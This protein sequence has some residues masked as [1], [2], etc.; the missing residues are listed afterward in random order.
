MDFAA[1]GRTRCQGSISSQPEDTLQGQ[2]VHSRLTF[3]ILKQV[4][5]REFVKL[6]EML[7]KL[8]PE[9]ISAIP[10]LSVGISVNIENTIY[11]VV[12]FLL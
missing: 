8:D 7:W 3:E 5:R 1:W 10:I 2:A 6:L 12:L 9:Q 4:C 11:M